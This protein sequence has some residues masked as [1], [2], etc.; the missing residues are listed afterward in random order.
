VY[1]CR[2]CILFF[3]RINLQVL[4]SFLA[5][6]HVT[7]YVLTSRCTTMCIGGWMYG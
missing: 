3:I 1:L 6:A 4:A 7:P 2:F 5:C